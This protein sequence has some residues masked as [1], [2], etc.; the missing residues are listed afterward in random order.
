MMNIML[1]DV[2]QRRLVLHVSRNR[3]VVQKIAG[4]ACVTQPLAAPVTSYAPHRPD[5]STDRLLG[6][7]LWVS[8]YLVRLG[9]LMI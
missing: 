4:P 2:Q 7:L 3:L 5:L 8:L 6:H 9:R 1:S